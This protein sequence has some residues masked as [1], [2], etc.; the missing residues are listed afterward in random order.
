MQE[1]VHRAA[2]AEI[3]EQPVAVEMEAVFLRA[4]IEN[5]EQDVLIDDVDLHRGDAVP[6]AALVMSFVTRPRSSVR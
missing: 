2:A 3:F 1:H 4:E 5:A 6:A